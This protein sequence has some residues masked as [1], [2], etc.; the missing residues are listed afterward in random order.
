MYKPY[1]LVLMTFLCTLLAAPYSVAREA[2][3]LE[4]SRALAHRFA[5][6]LQVELKSA[7]A[8]GGPVHA[9]SVC[10]EEA[11]RIASK[12]SRE[13]GAKVARTS[14]QSRNTINAPDPRQV[15]VL[16]S[17]FQ[18]EVQATDKRVEFFSQSYGDVRYMQVIRTGGLCLTCHGPVLADDLVKQLDL[19]YPFDQARGY[20][21][22]SLR[23]AFSITWPQAGRYAES[24]DEG[25]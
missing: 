11:P 16:T 19:D 8:Q 25:R 2:T 20:E 17:Y 22:G 13:T 9:I 21:I 1:S 18:P 24:V 6:E 14:L 23:G 4:T 7:L 5:M 3:L 12:L 10:K 15:E